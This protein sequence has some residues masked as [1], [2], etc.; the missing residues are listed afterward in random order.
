MAR[1]L[2]PI[3]VIGLVAVFMVYKSRRV[4]FQCPA[5]GSSFKVSGLILAISPHSMGMQLIRCPKCHMQ[6]YLT[7]ISDDKE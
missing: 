5:C 6:S 7:P 3:V 1:F 2:T 4:H